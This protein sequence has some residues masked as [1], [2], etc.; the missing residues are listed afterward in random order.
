M[1]NMVYYNQLCDTPKEARKTIEAGNL[2]G[3]TDI[4]PMWRIK[5][6]TEV[7]GPQGEG[8]KIEV[9]ET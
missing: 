1:D 4:N 6:L 9:V 2:K 8:W 5:R 3:K 7:F